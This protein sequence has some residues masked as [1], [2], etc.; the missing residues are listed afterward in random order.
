MFSQRGAGESAFT[1]KYLNI[2]YFGEISLI[3][4]KK[5]I[6]VGNTVISPYFAEMPNKYLEVS[7][8][9]IY[10][11]Y[12]AL[13][14]RPVLSGI[15]DFCGNCNF[16]QKYAVSIKI[17]HFHRKCTFWVKIALFPEPPLKNQQNS[18]VIVYVFTARGGRISFYQ[19][20]PKI[21]DILV[22]YHYF[23]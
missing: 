2:R 19:K 16:P 1:R 20:I 10:I 23:P 3:S 5:W 17:C 15:W 6:F 22:K 14:C 7:R 18:E 8:I 21:S 13:Y 11:H 9:C 12:T 4:M